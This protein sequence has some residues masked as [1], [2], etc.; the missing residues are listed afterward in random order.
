MLSL[1]AA[2]PAA[3]AQ[4]TATAP[5]PGVTSGL[6][7]APLGLALVLALLWGAACIVR[8]ISPAPPTG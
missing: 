8:R 4:S 6:L 3:A 2:I 5:G 1:A 7:Q